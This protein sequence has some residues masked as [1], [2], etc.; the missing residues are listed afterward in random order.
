MSPSAA[1]WPQFLMERFK[2]PYLENGETW[3]QGCYWSLRGNHIRSFRWDKNHRSWMTL[4]VSDNQY[5]RLFY[6]QLGFLTRLNCRWLSE[7][8]ASRRR[9]RCILTDGYSVFY[10]QYVMCRCSYSSR[11]RRTVNCS[12]KKKMTDDNS[13]INHWFSSFFAFVHF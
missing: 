11:K 3:S 4:K 6:R 7:T 1:V 5:G 12:E 2:W 10:R 13:N 8:V 9:R